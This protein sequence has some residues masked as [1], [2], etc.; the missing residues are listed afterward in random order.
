MTSARIT[1]TGNARPYE[2]A[3]G[4][5]Y[6]QR[7]PAPIR[8]TFAPDHTLPRVP[9]RRDGIAAVAIMAALC[10]VVALLAAGVA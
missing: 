2:V 10:V 9:T 6:T 1:T 8:D 4:Y 7:N 3:T 5:R